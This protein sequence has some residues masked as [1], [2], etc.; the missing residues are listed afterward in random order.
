MRVTFVFETDAP[1]TAD[2]AATLV[3]EFTKRVRSR[4]PLAS[5]EVECIEASVVDIPGELH[6]RR[7]LAALR[8][9]EPVE[10]EQPE[11]PFGL[12]DD[13]PEA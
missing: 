13:L 10:D 5:G 6:E 9:A 3:D 1:Y 4:T 7:R 11:I 8:D 2:F 12:A